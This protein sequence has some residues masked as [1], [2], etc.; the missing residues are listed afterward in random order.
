MSCIFCDIREDEENRIE[1][2]VIKP[3]NLL[4]IIWKLFWI[5]KS[6][7]RKLFLPF[8]SPHH[9]TLFLPLSC[10]LCFLNT[11]N[12]RFVTI[13]SLTFLLDMHTNRLS[14]LQHI[15][16]CRNQTRRYNPIHIHVTAS[17]HMRI[18]N[19]DNFIYLSAWWWRLLLYSQ[20]ASRAAGSLLVILYD[21]SFYSL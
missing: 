7:S 9:L 3:S 11:E 17:F 10:L 6:L 20:P 14:W 18:Q 13:F 5:G 8:F 1:N 4:T 19:F 12:W 21:F 2:K 15:H 16:S